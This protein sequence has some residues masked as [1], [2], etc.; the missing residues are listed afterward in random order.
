MPKNLRQKYNEVCYLFP[1]GLV[2]REREREKP[3][4]AKC[5]QLE[6]ISKEHT[7]I[8]LPSLSYSLKSQWA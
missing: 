3:D 8:H 7:S 2:K 4:M 1:N 6:N 5:K